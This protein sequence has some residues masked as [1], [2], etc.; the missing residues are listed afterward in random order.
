MNQ[1]LIAIAAV[2]VMIAAGISVFVLANPGNID[3]KSTDG[4]L[5]AAGREIK[6][7]ES[8]E[9]GIVTVGRIG[10][11]RYL[12]C[13]DVN[14][15]IIEVDLADTEKSIGG[16]AYMHAYDYSKLAHHAN[17]SLSAPTVE[18][19]AKKNPDLVVISE[20]TWIGFKDN[21]DILSKHTNVVILHE[22][23]N[24][25]M[26]ENGK[27]HEVISNNFMIL[28]K[29]LNK[30]DR[31][32]EM[33]NGIQKNI[34]ELRSLN[35]NVA[36]TYVAGLTFQGSNPLNTTF[37]YYI[38]LSL[39]NAPNVMNEDADAP[40]KKVISVEDFKKLS[41]GNMLVDPS[42]ASRLIDQDSQLVMKILYEQNNDSD[43]KN[44]VKIFSTIPIVSHS[45]NIDCALASAYFAA[46][47]IYGEYS[48]S[49]LLEKIENVFELFYGDNG[50]KAFESMSEYFEK[51]SAKFGQDMPL[52]TEVKIVKNNGV[53]SLVKI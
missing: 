51:N 3:D 42:S 9:N 43:A 20:R 53:Y 17:D 28:G 4:L 41:F 38:P 33:I 50:K 25:I 39:I 46:H 12:S 18:S 32:K 5:D 11:L 27:V 44:D 2:V 29:I 13:F 19:I 14:E 16:R 1:K 52:I 26:D 36:K 8:L 31:A 23:V 10:P 6:V 49:E 47:A 37:P 40:W 24:E 35:G 15:N 21:V 48:D 34:D 30:E 22:S 45:L 7:T